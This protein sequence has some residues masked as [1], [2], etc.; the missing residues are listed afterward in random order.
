MKVYC[1]FLPAPMV[2]TVGSIIAKP[3]H[4]ILLYCNN[5]NTNFNFTCEHQSTK[6]VL[7]HQVQILRILQYFV[8]ELNDMAAITEWIRQARKLFGSMKK[9]LLSNKRI[10]IDIR[11]RFYQVIVVNVAL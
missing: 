11:R 5:N 1:P 9:Q 10:R 8:P 6:K 7:L 4:C 3:Y 2:D